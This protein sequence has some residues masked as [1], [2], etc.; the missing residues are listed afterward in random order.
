MTRMMSWPSTC[1]PRR[2]C[3]RRR[4]CRAAGGTGRRSSA[5]GRSGC[6]GRSAGR[7]RSRRP[8]RGPRPPGSSAAWAWRRR[9]RRRP[10]GWTGCWRR[11]R[12][13]RRRR[14]ARRREDRVAERRAADD[15]GQLELVAAGH[16]DAGHVRELVHQRRVVGVLAALGPHRDDLGG[17]QLAEEGV[18]DLDDL[19]AEGGRGRDDRDPGAGPP[20]AATKSFRMVRRRSLSSAPPMIMR[21]PLGMTGRLAAARVAPVQRQ[22]AVVVMRHAKAEPPDPRT[23]NVS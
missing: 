1:R 6:A 10:C 9:R 21:G 14:R 8:G 20:L 12:C 23:P 17:A 2:R 22:P 3:P 11:R 19:G 16:E 13:R 18:V 4:P 5:A 15:R 7:S